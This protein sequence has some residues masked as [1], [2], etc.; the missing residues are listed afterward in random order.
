MPKNVSVV[1]NE[2]YDPNQK[3]YVAPPKNLGLTILLIYSKWSAENGR[4][5]SNIVTAQQSSIPITLKRYVLRFLMVP[6][7]KVHDHLKRKV[8][9]CE[10]VHEPHPKVVC[11]IS[12]CFCILQRIT[13]ASGY[14]FT[15]CNTLGIG[16]PTTPKEFTASSNTEIPGS[17]DSSLGPLGQR[18][19]KAQ[20]TILISLPSTSSVRSQ[21]K[22]K[23]F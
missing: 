9:A 18:N 22:L 19:I 3:V 13:R 4:D 10:H 17:I 14:L 15:Y 7:K 8:V 12:V 6:W 21:S 2:L 16:L 11:G 1:P 23:C 20:W 5:R